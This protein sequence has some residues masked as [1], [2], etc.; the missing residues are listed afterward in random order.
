[1]I[2]EDENLNS[3]IDS[4]VISINKRDNETSEKF[5]LKRNSLVEALELSSKTPCQKI[6]NEFPIKD[7]NLPKQNQSS[8]KQNEEKVFDFLDKFCEYK[9]RITNNADFQKIEIESDDS[10]EKAKMEIDLSLKYEFNSGNF[11]IQKKV[12][13]YGRKN[14]NFNFSHDLNEETKFIKNSQEDLNFNDGKKVFNK[15]KKNNKKRQIID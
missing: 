7:I 4:K 14:L 15:L 1:M 12:E 13:S 11:P 3:I 8:M 5:I 9:N 10:Y 2:V 6:S